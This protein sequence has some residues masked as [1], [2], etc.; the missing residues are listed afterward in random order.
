MNEELTRMQDPHEEQKELRGEERGT[1]RPSPPLPKNTYERLPGSRRRRLM[2]GLVRAVPF[3]LDVDPQSAD[4]QSISR[5]WQEPFDLLA[6]FSDADG[7]FRFCDWYR[8][9]DS[10]P[11][12]DA[13]DLTV[14]QRFGP[15][16]AEFLS[17]SPSPSE[18]TQGLRCHIEV[19]DGLP[20]HLVTFRALSERAIIDFILALFPRRGYVEM[21][22]AAA[23]WRS[24]SLAGTASPLLTAAAWVII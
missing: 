5:W 18:A 7:K 19:R 12:V 6:W 1:A 10:F 22:R 14:R 23:G 17:P 15:L 16:Y 21:D 8:I 2:V 24:I 13:K 11:G 9:G 3:D 20:A 4:L